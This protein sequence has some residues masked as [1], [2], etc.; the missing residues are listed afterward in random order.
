MKPG[1]ARTLSAAFNARPWGL[2]VPPNW[3]MLGAFGLLGVVNPGFW[4]VGLGLEIGY[5]YALASSE[6][7]RATLDGATVDNELEWAAKRARLLGQIEPEDR[8]AHESF[9]ARCREIVAHQAASDGSAADEQAKGLARLAWVQLRLLAARTAIRRVVRDADARGLDRRITE[10]ER[11]RD[12]AASDE[13][14]RSLEG[15][16]EI[17]RDR[18]ARQREAGDKL[19]YLDAELERLRQ[20]VELIREQALLA[21]DAGGVS[22]TIDALGDTLGE[23]SRWIAEQRQLLGEVDDLLSEPPSPSA[24]IGAPKRRVPQA[25]EPS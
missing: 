21:H 23:S 10:L 18:A 6:R 22:R 4:L 2:L 8:A 7:F 14:K 12:A 19:A 24:L 20:Q 3:I 5:L 13:L 16:I 9:V 17:V 1:F 11:S 15:Q 25:E